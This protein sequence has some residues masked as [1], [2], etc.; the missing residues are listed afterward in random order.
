MKAW[1]LLAAITAAG[2]TRAAPLPEHEVARIADA[3]YRA[4][5]GSKARVP[6]GVLSVRVAN[7]AEA[8]MVCMNT[9]RNNHKRWESAGKPGDFIK[10]LGAKYCPPSVDPTGHKNWVNNVSKIIAGSN[11]KTKGK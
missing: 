3:I 1:L 5:G 9:I 10:Y 11:N 8:R 7:A 4:E 2:I 6:Y